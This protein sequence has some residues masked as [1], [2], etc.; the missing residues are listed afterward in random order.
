MDAFR[1]VNI[2]GYFV[3]DRRGL[4]RGGT[5]FPIGRQTIHNSK[6][7]MVTNKV[8]KCQAIEP[9]PHP[10]PKKARYATEINENRRSLLPAQK[11]IAYFSLNNSAASDSAVLNA[12]QKWEVLNRQHCSK[13]QQ[14]C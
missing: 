8:L 1:Y 6:L 5:L 3:F 10:L 14:N 12:S 9:F 4:R 13:S 11:R 7:R 2:H